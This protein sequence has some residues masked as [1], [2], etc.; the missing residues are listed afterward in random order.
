M[1]QLGK[2]RW[3][4]YDFMVIAKSMKAVDNLPKEVLLDQVL[5]YDHVQS[6]SV[7]LKSL[8]GVRN[9]DIDGIGGI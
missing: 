9:S 2:N 6:K 7:T 8:H 1:K 3:L 5:H 4:A